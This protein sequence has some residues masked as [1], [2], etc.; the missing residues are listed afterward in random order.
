MATINQRLK[1]LTSLNLGTIVLLKVDSLFNFYQPEETRG[2]GLCYCPCNRSFKVNLEHVLKCPMLAEGLRQTQAKELTGDKIARLY[3]AHID[4]I[5]VFGKSWRLDE[6][7]RELE[8]W[9][10]AQFTK[11]C[12]IV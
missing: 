7:L 10:L 3:T 12:F 5:P 9:Y 4:D 8:K 2:K 6:E 11:N 1:L